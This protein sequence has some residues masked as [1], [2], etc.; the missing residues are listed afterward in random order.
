MPLLNTIKKHTERMSVKLNTFAT[1]DFSGKV[2]LIILS[3]AVGLAA[4]CA[5]ALLKLCIGSMAKLF[6]HGFTVDNFNWLLLTLPL[7]GFGIAGLYQKYVIKRSV[8]HGVER[9]NRNF[10]A[11]RYGYPLGEVFSMFFTSTFTLG[12]GGSAGSE[13]PIAT[14]GG[15]LGSNV[16]KALRVGPDM[17]RVMVAAGAAA[18]IA[19]I[20]KAPVGGALFA[21]EVLAV[22]VNSVAVIAIFTACITSG[23]TAFVLSD[24]TTDV[25]FGSA[26]PF[27]M[28]MM[29]AVALLGLFCAAYSIYY[30]YIMTRLQAWYDGMSSMLRKVLISGAVV[31][32]SLLLLPGL[33]G[34]GYGFMARLMARGATV[35]ANNSAFNAL[36]GT[37]TWGLL[38]MCLAFMAVKPFATVS[39][40]SGG[41][42]AGDFAPSLFAG[43]V[44]G[45]MFA[46]LMG[47]FGVEIPAGYAAYFGMAA[48]MACT[49]RAPIMAIFLVVEMGA[50][51]SLLL[52]VVV[53]TAVAYLGY[54]AA[55]HHRKPTTAK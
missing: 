48:V 23:M 24:F 4:G 43:C 34:E 52:P 21:F 26:V 20:F 7:I 10:A 31:G 28:K 42:V 17:M 39:T 12:F 32:V 25:P 38:A 13:G 36:V 41:G 14:V 35:V 55:V 49:Q 37:H 54:Y 6:E 46:T 47:V 33:Y 8:A 51:Y 9:M 45:F 50:G 22:S 15:V 44:T 16:G 40:T 53:A 18:G 1:G 11:Q 27:D 19:G 29:W 3:V 5:A 2:L 30:Q